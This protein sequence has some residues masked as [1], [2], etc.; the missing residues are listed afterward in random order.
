MPSKRSQ[1]LNGWSTF[2]PFR[3]PDHSS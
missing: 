2:S 1:R 3:T